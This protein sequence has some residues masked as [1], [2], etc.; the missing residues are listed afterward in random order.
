LL[1]KAF[2]LAVVF[3]AVDQMSGPISKMGTQ[4]GILDEKTKAV[5][6]RLNGFKNMA[7]VG[8]GI[9]LAGGVM[10]KGLLSATE[11]A[12]NLQTSI[13]G[14]KESLG[15]TNDEFERTLKLAQNVGIPT[16]FSSEQVGDIMKAM[17]TS[18]LSKDQILNPDT[19]K[20]YVN[21]ADVQAQVKHENA[22]DV[23]SSAVNMAH[24]YQLY[25]P[26]Q[27]EPFLN[28]L[29]GAL[30]HTH[31]T[32]EEFS[33]T[34]K[35][36]AN[37]ARS[38]GMSSEDT[39]DT[40]AW[41]SRMGFGSGRGGTN[42]ADFLQRSIYGSSGKKADGAMETAGFVKN[43]HS[44]FQDAN[45]NFVG[46]PESAKIMQDFAQRFGNDSSKMSPLL[47]DIFG[48]Q[49]ERI[50][51]MMTS[52][53]AAEQY[54]NVK[55]QIGGTTG[56]NKTQ[57]DLNKTWQGQA[58]QFETTLKDIEQAFGASEKGVL[59]PIVEG[60]NNILGKILEFEQA[61]PK[62]MQ[63]IATFISIATAIALVTGPLL[64]L[65]GA[66]GYL[67]EAN[68]ISTGFRLLGT[69]FKS[70]L[71]PITL[72]ITA[73]YLLYQAWQ[74]DFGG[75][76]EKTEAVFE[77]IKKEAPAIEEKLH[78]IAKALGFETDKGFQIPKW[79]T[80][81]MGLFVGGK[82][83][84][85]ALGGLSKLSSLGTV[86]K[87]MKNLSLAGSLLKGGG[88][89]GSGLLNKMFGKTTI[90]L[91][92]L[93]T[94]K[95]LNLL[96][97]SDT[98][99]LIGEGLKGIPSAVKEGVK[100]IGPLLKAT[101]KEILSVM[102]LVGGSLKTFGSFALNAGKAALGFGGN[103]IK[104]AAQAMASAVRM[105]AAWL[106]GLGPI[107][108]I[109]AGI[110]AVLALLWVAWQNDW[111]NIREHFAQTVQWITNKWHELENWFS[112]LGQRAEEWGKNLIQGFVNGVESLAG[113]IKDKVSGVFDNN[114]VKTIKELLG[115]HSPSRLMHEFGQYT[116]QGFAN[117]MNKDM[118][119]VSN[120]SSKLTDL[121]QPTLQNRT[122]GGST[123]S[124]ENASDG[125][126]A[127]HPGAIVINA[128]PGQSA[129]EIA[130]AVMKKIARTMRNQ[131]YSRSTS[132]VPQ[133]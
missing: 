9:T 93:I 57:E 127:I 74:T 91:G 78:S 65:V 85:F 117:G 51:M 30:L 3:S 38:M 106:I 53:G 4:L 80:T 88:K 8:G 10:A 86:I 130:D 125:S 123:S 97:R 35:Y 92:K 83:I 18:G 98:A 17:A 99:K 104:L 39:L 94:L 71:G 19:L 15:L 11:S 63:W 72:L 20:E 122:S 95:G 42:F 107:G 12:G 79:V 13:M 56:I 22:P 52:S 48:T 41:L 2:E 73:G 58:K 75:I 121:A 118:S 64:V 76:R 119:L 131:S 44:V 87:D 23:V 31:D 89:L 90:D 81:L 26:E 84:N 34:Y 28:S 16:I 7:F 59:T 120:A 33:T 27:I 112:G 49:G 24:Q 62:I 115:I 102:K 60:L 103:L 69:S 101:F 108:W 68:V 82:T 67:R 43:G 54:T 25:S 14:L 40:T 70:A 61:H 66:L 109:I 100:G 36:I 126:L 37:Q 105:A 124:K 21:F 55:E 47:H 110:I 113:W 6:Q 5:Q 111:G 29:N 128:A 50:A 32:A 96:K 133:W 129:D 46:I 116:V 77:W 45:G 1:E 114:V 132:Y